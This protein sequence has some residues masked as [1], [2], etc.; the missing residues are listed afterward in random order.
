MYLWCS[1]SGSRQPLGRAMRSF[2]GPAH[3]QHL[4]GWWLYECVVRRVWPGAA[5][6]KEAAVAWA[7]STHS[8]CGEFSHQWG[9]KAP[10][11][12]R[13]LTKVCTSAVC[14]FPWG[15]YCSPKHS[16]VGE[17]ELWGPPEILFYTLLMFMIHARPRISPLLATC[18]APSPAAPPHGA[19]G[20]HPWSLQ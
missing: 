1:N 13:A 18:R 6:D 2:W 14:T 17:G 3:A 11:A 8:C 16:W 15:V 7:A 20:F 12:P 19:P 10:E 4:D 9:Q 5:L